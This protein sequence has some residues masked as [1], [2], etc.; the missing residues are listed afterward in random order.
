M[1]SKMK[2]CI[3]S[4]FSVVGKEGSTNDGND[5]I[6]K[7]WEDANSHFDDIELIAKKDKKGNII[8]VWG[9]MSDF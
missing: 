4:P 9:L 6:N 8:G 3:K 5:F 7:L 1:N 2:K